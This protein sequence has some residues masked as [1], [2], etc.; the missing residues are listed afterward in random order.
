MN[1][2]D[3]KFVRDTLAEFFN[4]CQAVR[5]QDHDPLPSPE[6]LRCEQALMICNQHLLEME[7]CATIQA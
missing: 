7:A 2:D 1:H 6:E 3:L 5:A 4:G